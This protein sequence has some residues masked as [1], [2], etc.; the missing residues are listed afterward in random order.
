MTDDQFWQY[1][2]ALV[3]KPITNMQSSIF[4]GAEEED[5]RYAIFVEQI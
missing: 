1:L 3:D 5:I 2:Q 4:T